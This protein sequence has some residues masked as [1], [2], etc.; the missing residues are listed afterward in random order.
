[1]VDQLGFDPVDGGSL[2]ES[3][4]QQPGTPVYGKDY[5]ADRTLEAL[6]EAPSE[7]PAEF[8]GI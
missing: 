8:R 3:R 6:A 1:L 7:R 4:R 2:Q 5:N